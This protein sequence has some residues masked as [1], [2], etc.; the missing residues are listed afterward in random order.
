MNDTTPACPL[1]GTN[2]IRDAVNIRLAALG[3]AYPAGPCEGALAP[4]RGILE[5]L[6]EQDRILTSHL[7]PVDARIQS[8]LESYLKDCGAPVVKLPSRTFVLDQPGMARELSLPP[9]HD[10]Y[11]SPILKSFRVKQGVLHNPAKDRRTTVGVFH[12]AED[13]LPIP[14]DKLAVPRK[15]F[16]NILAAALNE[17]PDANLVVPYTADTDKPARLW[18]SLLLRPLVVPEVPGFIHERRMEVRFFAPSSLVSNLDFVESIFGNG[19]DPRLA[20]NDATLDPLH[21]TGHTGCVILAPHLITKRKKDLGLPH[22]SEATERQKRDGMCWTKEDELYNG[23]NAFKLTARDANGV[24]VTI[25]ADNYYGYCKKEVK[26]MISF[27]ANLHG[28]AEEEHAGGAIA[29]PSYDLGE[30]FCEKDLGLTTSHTFADLVA[31]NPDL[32]TLQPEGYGIDKRFDNIAYVPEGACFSMTKQSITWTTADGKAPS[33]YLTPEVTY[34]LPSGY[35]VEMVKSEID[36]DWHLVGTVAEGTFCHKPCTVSGGGKSEISKSI[37]DAVIAGRVFVADYQKD[38]DLVDTLL[39]RDFSDRFRDAAKRGKDKR[40]ILSPDRSIGSLVK[41]LTP[42]SEFSD[43][44][45]AWLASIP[46][47]VKELIFVIKRVHK[48]GSAESWRT[49]FGVDL[50]NG[51]NGNELNYN[52]RPLSNRYLRV[53]YTPEGSWRTFSLRP[54]FMPAAKLQTEDDIT[55]SVIVPTRHLQ[56]K[57]SSLTQPAV[58]IAENCEMRLFQRPDDAIHR[59]YDKQTESDMSKTGVFL[60][61]YQP[62]TRTEVRAMARDVV[63][64]NKFTGPMRDHLAQ[65]ASGVGPDYCASSANPRLVDG[66]PSKNPRYLQDRQDITRPRDKYM[67]E[68]VARITRGLPAGSPAPIPVTSVLSGRRNNPPEKGVHPLSV[69][70][71]I[72]FMDLPELFAEFA[73]SMTGKSPSTTGAGSEGALT[74]G[75]FNALPTVVDLNNALLSYLLTGYQGFVTSAGCIGPDMRVDHDI[76]LLVPEVWGRM[77]PEERDPQWLIAQGMMERVPDVTVNGKTYPGARLGYRI[78]RDFAVRFFGRVFANPGVVLTEE[79]LKPELQ[80]AEVYAESMDTILVTDQRVAEMYFKDGT[81][82][83]ACPP[84]RALLGIM[85][86][87]KF[88]GMDWN[89]PAFRALFT[90][91]AVLNSD[92]YKARLEARRQVELKHLDAGIARLQAFIANPEYATVAEQQGMKQRLAEAQAE[93]AKVAAPAY[94]EFLKGS[95]GTDPWLHSLKK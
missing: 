82:D 42:S 89:S 33:I 84:I 25:I 5:V 43:E 8:F 55:A 95:L 76:S 4:A 44:Y 15:V 47:H 29:R 81:I 30:E 63:G 20:A 23:G 34:I 38:F 79:M 73:T 75:P 41:L 62:L 53:G 93:R 12:V 50:I 86:Y 24:I 26:T 74:K 65:F 28:L 2:D 92:W 32:M 57:P 7:C 69:H 49:R 60:S 67:T 6:R 46:A 16:A 59:G 52:D 51:I 19:G 22:V 70:G 35:Q 85:A 58:K 54:D 18:I 91:E 1:R 39:A 48:A 77:K 94:T 3:E 9:A 11:E 83:G 68:T 27:S 21:W 10:T 87:G 36:G 80:S 40:A 45:N 64:F 88:E 66:K 14:D 71:P 61:N 37:S 56:G 78:T 31:K 90:P 13:G 72:H 17:T